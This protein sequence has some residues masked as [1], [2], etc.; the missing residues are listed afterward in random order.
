MAATKSKLVSCLGYALRV[1]KTLDVPREVQGLL[2]VALHSLLDVQCEP[3]MLERT[4][5]V[6]EKIVKVPISISAA[7]SGSHDGQPGVDVKHLT[8]RYAAPEAPDE[9]EVIEAQGPDC[10]EV[11]LSREED[12]PERD[13]R[14]QSA[15]PCD[16][17]S[18][19]SGLPT[20]SCAKSGKQLGGSGGRSIWE[21]LGDP[22]VFLRSRLTKAGNVEEACCGLQQLRQEYGAILKQASSSD[23]QAGAPTSVERAWLLRLYLEMG[24]VVR[25]LKG[26]MTLQDALDEIEVRSSRCEE[27]KALY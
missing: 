13:D 15:D 2:Q 10:A 14:G 25:D 3:K 1:S 21:E 26:G 5:P 4:M 19:G 20:T 27:A 22:E 6:P 16:A 8:G 7:L 24:E 11:T 17:L 18:D 12:M 23:R 9:L